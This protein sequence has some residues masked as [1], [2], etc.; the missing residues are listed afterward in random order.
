MSSTVQIVLDASKE[1]QIAKIQKHYP[2]TPR[3]FSDAVK[4]ILS[5]AIEMKLSVIS[6]EE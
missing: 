5:E 1:N 4:Y 2:E 6:K 3:G